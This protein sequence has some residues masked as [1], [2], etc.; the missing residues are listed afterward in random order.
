MR[1][2][3]TVG[4]L[5][6]PA[7]RTAILQPVFSGEWGNPLPETPAYPDPLQSSAAGASARRFRVTQGASLAIPPVTIRDDD[8]NPILTYNGTETLST[9]VWAGGNLPGDF[10]VPTTW[11][12]ADDGTIQL[13]PIS[14]A[15]TGGLA[16]GRYDGLTRLTPARADPIDVYRFTIDILSYAGTAAAPVYDSLVTVD[17]LE[18]QLPRATVERYRGQLGDAIAAATG[19]IE[20]YCGRKL[21]LQQFDKVYRPGRTR[22]IYLDTWPVARITM[23]RTDLCVVATIQNTDVLT[24]QR[25]TVEMTATTLGFVRI[26][27]GVQSNFLLTLNQFVT[28][29]DLI[30]AIN[31]DGGGWSATLANNQPSGS[32]PNLGAFAVS[33]LNLNPGVSGCLAQAYELQTYQRD[34]M[35]YIPNMDKG[36]IE[37]TENVAQAFRYADRSYGQGFG[38]SWSSAS[39]PRFAGVRCQ[40]QAGYAIQAADI[41]AGYTPVPADLRRA[42][43]FA[44]QAI[45]ET[46]PAPNVIS[47]TD[48]AYSYRLASE[49]V[50][51]PRS[52]TQILMAGNYVSPRCG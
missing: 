17:W 48:G 3:P 35:R 52:V 32:Q 26:A 49:P 10:A 47:E 31:A 13:S 44:V 29:A 41:A 30:A 24:N 50:T 22:K 5:N 11:I 37:L 8:G 27:S 39:D 15:Q 21:V 43:V 45:L 16:P 34:I 36:Y 4:T 6:T 7:S 2:F 42:V 9:E 19:A 20:S 40:Y 28:F 23:V 18:Q 12:S 38:W 1:L 33:D 46:T 51:L 25:A 14:A